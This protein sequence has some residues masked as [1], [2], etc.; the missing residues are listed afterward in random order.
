MLFLII[1]GFDKWIHKSM[2]PQQVSLYKIVI[3]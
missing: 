3:T 2:P 1:L